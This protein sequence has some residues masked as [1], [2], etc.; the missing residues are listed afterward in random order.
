MAKYVSRY[1][2]SSVSGEFQIKNYDVIPL[3]T[4][5]KEWQSEKER[6]IQKLVRIG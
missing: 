5:T 3:H 2:V 6:K 1:P 4:Y